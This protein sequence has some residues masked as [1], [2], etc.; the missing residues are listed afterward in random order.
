MLQE[1]CNKKGWNKIEI[2][3]SEQFQGQEKPVMII[4][5][6][7]TKTEQSRSLGF[8]NDVKV[9]FIFYLDLNG[10]VRKISMMSLLVFFNLFSARMYV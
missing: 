6:V 4:T 10:S 8:L 5:M 1:E 2:G 9:S 7:R 3:V